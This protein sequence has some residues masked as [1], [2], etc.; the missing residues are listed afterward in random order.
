MTLNEITEAVDSG[1]KV[2]YKNENY[3]VEKD[4]GGYDIVCLGTGHRIGLVWMDGTTMNGEESDFFMKAPEPIAS[5]DISTTRFE[6]DS[7]LTGS[8]EFIDNGD[9]FRTEYSA[10]IK[11]TK[12]PDSLNDISIGID[13]VDCLQTVNG[14]TFSLD[15]FDDIL[16]YSIESSMT[17]DNNP[18]PV[19]VASF[20]HAWVSSDSTIEYIRK[21][22]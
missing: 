3:I 7:I 14:E 22:K 12:K 11:I 5:G 6:I 20:V 9:V 17:A 13:S 15:G 2:Y 18:D 8:V 10:D 16:R 4:R 1:E 21:Q 19:M